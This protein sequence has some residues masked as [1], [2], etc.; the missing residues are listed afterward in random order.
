MQTPITDSCHQL[1]LNGD[2]DQGAG[3]LAWGGEASCER[4]QIGVALGR[5]GRGGTPGAR[6]HLP[7]RICVRNSLS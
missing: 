1:A 6:T 5:P 2:S 3:N 7:T 4:E